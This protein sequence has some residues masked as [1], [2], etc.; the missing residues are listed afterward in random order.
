MHSNLIFNIYIK[1]FKELPHIILYVYVYVY[2]SNF[3]RIYKVLWSLWKYRKKLQKL[4]AVY[5]P[6]YQMDKEPTIHN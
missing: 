2:N 3:Y 6:T 4:T 5:M 1:T